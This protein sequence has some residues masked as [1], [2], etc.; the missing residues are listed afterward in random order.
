MSSNKTAHVSLLLC[1]CFVLLHRFNRFVQ[2]VNRNSGRLNTARSYMSVGG[3]T[4]QHRDPTGVLRRTARRIARQKATTLLSRAVGVS[5]ER[6]IED[7]LDSRARSTNMKRV[8]VKNVEVPVK[9][10][11][12]V[13][14]KQTK[15]V[16]RTETKRVLVK[17][18]VEVPGYK[19]VDEEYTT[20]EHRAVMRDK[21]VWVKKVVQEEVMEPYE[22]RR[23]RKKKIPTTAVKEVEEWQDVTVTTDEAVQEDGFRVDEVE[24]TKLVE[25]KEEQLYELVPRLKDERILMSARDLGIQLKDQHLTRHIGTRTYTRNEVRDI[26]LDEF[27]SDTEV[28]S[29]QVRHM[30]QR[31]GMVVSQLRSEHRG[32]RIKLIRSGYPCEQAGLRAGDV[33]THV[34]GTEVHTLDQFRSVV[35]KSGK[36]LTFTVIRG[37]E[38]KRITVVKR[39]EASG[40]GGL[41]SSGYGYSSTS[42]QYASTS[43]QYSSSN[44]F[45]SSMTR[46]SLLRA[47]GSNALGISGGAGKY[48]YHQHSSTYAVRDGQV[49]EDSHND[50]DVAFKRDS[51]GKVT[52]VTPLDFQ[53]LGN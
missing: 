23:T 4:M 30:R 53:G 35:Y 36:S 28:V 11:V 49:I 34:D 31:L 18:L 3:T 17:R 7:T 16:P 6:I 33:I 2:P 19:E 41:S 12:K 42:N 38:T 44:Q 5:N 27:P 26:A 52:D 13:A 29:V 43:N 24:D 1:L 10:R 14:V 20:V 47:A 37:S 51:K 22:V 39:M 15:I 9:R 8:I 46:G 50:V 32:V 40:G 48:E 25:V 45:S 21:E